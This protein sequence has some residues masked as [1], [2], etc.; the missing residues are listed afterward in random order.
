MRVKKIMGKAVRM[1]TSSVYRPF[2]SRPAKRR[3]GDR[4]LDARFDDSPMSDHLR[5]ERDLQEDLGFCISN[6]KKGRR[7]REFVKGYLFIEYYARI[8]T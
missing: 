6:H 3:A 1:W 5:K 7:N 8:V 4:L 2:R